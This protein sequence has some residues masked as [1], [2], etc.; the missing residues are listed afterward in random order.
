MVKSII[1]NKI[2]L[3]ITRHLGLP[4]GKP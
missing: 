3:L 4:F 2:T 1:Y